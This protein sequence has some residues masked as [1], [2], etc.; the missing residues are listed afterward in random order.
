[1]NTAPSGCTPA[2]A[3]GPVSSFSLG[4]GDFVPKQL[5]LSQDGTT[6]Y[7]I[8]SNLNSILVFNIPGQAASAIALSG[9]PM[10][11]SA[12]LTPDGTL[13]YRRRQRRDGSRCEYGRGRRHSADSVSRGPVSGFVRAAISHHLQSRSARVEAVEGQRSRRWL[14]DLAGQNGKLIWDG[15]GLG[16]RR[17]TD[18]QRLLTPF[19]V[20]GLRCPALR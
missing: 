1:M 2:V 19:P 14:I 7:M 11:L 3:D 5:I 10:P 6:A 17:M 20:L 4:H 15:A 16:R 9:N 18:D 13:L 8:T 12:A